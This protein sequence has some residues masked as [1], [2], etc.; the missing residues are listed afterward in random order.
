MKHDST[1]LQGE[2]NLDLIG[3]LRVLRQRAPLIAMC[4][5]LTGGAAFALSK[6]QRREY[7]AT[8]QVLFRDAQ[9]DQQAAGLQVVNQ[10]NPQPQTDTN[11]RLATLPRVAA[12]TAAELDHGLTQKQVSNA[13]SVSQ[14]TDTD[15]ASVTAT[16][17]SPTFS[18]QLANAYAHNVIEG[19]QRADAN[20]YSNAL[21]A[22]NLQYAALTETQRSGVEGADLKDRANSLQILSQLQS[23]EVQLEQGAIPPTAA[24][25]PKLVRNTLLGAFVGLL[26]GLALAFLLQR[27]DRRLREPGD[28]EAVYGVPLLAVVPES[29][30]IREAQLSNGAIRQLPPAEAE[31][32]GL[33]RAHIRYFNVDRQMKVIVVVSAAPGDGKTTVSRNLAMAAA[34]VGSRVLYVEAD[35]RR[36]VAATYFGIEREPGLSEVLLGENTLTNAIQSVKFATKGTNPELD[37]L[38]AGGMLPPNPPQVME[39]EAMELLM[40]AARREY[41]LVLIDTPPLVLLPDAFPLMRRADGVVIVSRLGHNRTDVASRLRETLASVDAPV[42]GVVANGY[43][44][45][46][47]GPS[48]GYAYTYDYSEYGANDH[49]ATQVSANGA[50]ADPST[51]VGPR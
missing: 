49:A 48:Y 22:V 37:V 25:S 23:G 31:I 34:T 3:T 38:V 18:A 50:S 35:L 17:T 6:A 19:R 42:V 32:F 15:L 1:A 44:R 11:L 5:L 29:S 12:E 8:A 36:P 33:L 47:G 45:A 46:H 21:K 40:D 24:S 14:V 51:P 43:R 16:W 4:V 9:L 2:G 27:L 39:S 13:V 10:T 26:L 7:T 41:D 28:L 30:A 20:Y